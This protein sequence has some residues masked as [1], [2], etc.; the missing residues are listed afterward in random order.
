M[1]RKP[2]NTDDLMFDNSDEF[3][4]LD[5]GSTRSDKGSPPKGL[6][7]YLKNVV[8]SVRNLS[9][10]VTKEM[11]PEAFNLA[12]SIKEDQGEGQNINIKETVSKYKGY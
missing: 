10:S 11:Y 6:K 3:F 5:N 1:A 4:P 8:K 9:V 2:N 12:N 7:G